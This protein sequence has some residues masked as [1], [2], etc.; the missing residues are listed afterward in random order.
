[1]MSAF[2]K[3]WLG[4]SASAI[5]SA[6]TAFALPTIAIFSLHATPLQIGALSALEVLPWPF[7]SMP[8]GVLADRFS[9]R[10]ILIAADALRFAALA[11]IPI[12]AWLGR[13]S[14]AQLYV[15]ALATGIGTVFFSISYQSFLPWI[16]SSE[17]LGSANAKLEAS[18]SGSQVLGTAAGG[19]IV[20][21]LGGAVAIAIDALSYVVSIVTLCLMQTNEEP[22]SGRRLTAKQ[23]VADVREGITYT[24]AFSDI[25][26]IAGA[27]ATVNFGF[28]ISDSMTLLFVYRIVHLQP[29][30]VGVATGLA[31]F[32]FVGALFAT[33]VQAVLGLRLALLAS[34]I[35]FGC[36]KASILLAQVAVPY[37]ILFLSSAL[38][39]IASLVFYV[40]QLS[41]RQARVPL[42]L[43]GRVTAT[44]RM[45]TW[46]IAPLGSMVGGGLGQVVGIRSTIA[47]GA[48]LGLAGALWLL[49]MR[50]QGGRIDAA[51]A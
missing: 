2:N 50:E 51:E 43:Q 45:V 18:N 15:V 19:G 25:R 17:H 5:G 46:G 27:I 26:C 39:S 37:V 6:M 38:T 29:G 10:A 40:N 41:Y 36:S 33:R 11:S 23:L 32:G 1:M 28:A 30:P 42:R 24:F 48:A 16:V 47:I 7:V 34:L 20:Q 4:Q 12:A 44:L 3:L 14:M 21:W 35:A 9:R 31:A 13:L 8:A 22:H 49:P